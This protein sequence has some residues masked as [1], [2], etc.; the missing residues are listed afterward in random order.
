MAKNESRRINPAAL[1]VDKDS[2]AALKT[3]TTYAPPSPEVSVASLESIE[4]EMID[5]QAAEAQAVAA[6]AAARDV[7]VAAEWKYHNAMIRMRDAVGGQYGRNS[8]EMQ[9]VGRKKPSEYKP[10]TRKG[11]KG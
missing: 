5:A 4:Q 2:L 7:A 8:N 11:S 9:K 3:I 6:A 10:R 1:Q